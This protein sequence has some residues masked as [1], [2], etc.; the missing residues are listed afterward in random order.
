VQR[1]IQDIEYTP[2]AMCV[3]NGNYIQYYILLRKEEL[4]WNLTGH[5][6]ETRHRL[7]FQTQFCRTDIFKKSVSNMGIK[8]YNKLPNYLK[9]LE[10]T[11]FF[12]KQL[13]TFLGSDVE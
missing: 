13:K 8:L 6:H 9:N 5:D 10:N 1:I 7:D 4:K 3:Y 12:K 11:T 2:G